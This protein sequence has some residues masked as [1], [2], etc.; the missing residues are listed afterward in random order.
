MFLSF[1]LVIFQRDLRLEIWDAMLPED[2]IAENGLSLED[3]VVH[4]RMQLNI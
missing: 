1:I 3:I 4:V 2:R